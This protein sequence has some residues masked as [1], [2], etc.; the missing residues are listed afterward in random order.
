MDNYILTDEKWWQNLLFITTCKAGQLKSWL[1][2]FSSKTIRK[3]GTMLV[4]TL[5]S[6]YPGSMN[7]QWTPFYFSWFLFLLPFSFFF[8]HHFQRMA[9]HRF[10]FRVENKSLVTAR[11]IGY[12]F[13]HEQVWTRMPVSVNSESTPTPANIMFCSAFLTKTALSCRALYLTSN[14]V[15]RRREVHRS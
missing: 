8:S 11:N 4:V 5:S 13:I 14:T 12:K 15:H 10:H 2:L 3:Q 7:S 9:C 1:W 6:C